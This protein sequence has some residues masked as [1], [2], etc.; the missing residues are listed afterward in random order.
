MRTFSIAN[1]PFRTDASLSSFFL[2][3]MRLACPAEAL[4]L[5]PDARLKSKED[6][7]YPYYSMSHILCR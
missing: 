3:L 7:P 1:F 6:L 4:K 2:Q 5:I